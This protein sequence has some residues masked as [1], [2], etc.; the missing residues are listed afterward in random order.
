M[1]SASTQSAGQG[2]RVLHPGARPVLA[3]RP[4]IPPGTTTH[5]C[6]GDE[7]GNSYAPTTVAASLTIVVPDAN[8][9]VYDVFPE[10]TN[11]RLGAAGALGL[12]IGDRALVRLAVLLN[13]AVHAAQ[14]TRK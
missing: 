12:M 3:P 10:A 7:Q 5:R 13:E 1:T 14:T 9:A 8:S 4:Q 11:I 2:R 6:S